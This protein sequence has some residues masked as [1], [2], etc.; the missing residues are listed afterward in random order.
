MKIFLLTGLLATIVAAEEPLLSCFYFN[1]GTGYLCQLT[2][3][4]PNGFDNFTEIDGIHLEGFTNENV[5][6]IHVA[7]GTST[8]IPRI[9]CD[10][11]PNIDQFD[12][13]GV[14]LTDID[15]NSFNGCSQIGWLYLSNNRISSISEMAFG[16]LRGLTLINLGDNLLTT[17][18]ENLFANQQNLTYL[19]LNNNLIGGFAAGT[20]RP[21]GNLQYLHIENLNITTFN[22]QFFTDN[23][24]LVYLYLGDN[25]ITLSANMFSGMTELR[26]ISLLNN[27]IS[28][29]PPGT[30]AGLPN[31]T[32]LDL[33]WNNF[34]NL[35]ADSFAGSGQLYHIDLSGNPLETIEE[36]AFRGLDAL[37]SLTLE[38]GRIRDLNSISLNNLPNLTYLALSI[39]SIEEIPAGFFE[40]MPRLDYIG[41][42]ANRIKTLRR[43]SFGNLTALRTLDLD[44]NIVNAID[45]AFIDDAVN[46]NTLNLDGNLCASNYFGNFMN[47]RDRYLPMLE[48]CFRNI[49]HIVDTTTENDGIYSFFEAPQPGIILRVRSDNEIQI[50]LTPFDFVW[51]PAIEIIIGSIN[52]T[53][54]AIRINDETNVVTVPTPNV[55][56]P[57]QWNDFRVTWAHQN[58]LVFNGNNTFPFMSYT[59]QQF[60]PVN[61]YGLRAVETRATWSVQPIFFDEI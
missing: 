57:D 6:A 58:V 8:I 3:N 18:P 37:L 24:N 42:W 50:S 40:S 17:L 28:E 46:L 23:S 7:W 10:T 43:S 13:F 12:F 60:F 22:S 45:K 29:I 44:R 48:R 36:D 25:R 56:R 59:M 21:L 26:F 31:L 38:R 15:D 5:T 9:I 51:T 33:N 14:G 53:R 49:R 11:F 55:I 32:A 34:T 41:L 47:S 61:F 30:F 39:N 27:G 54:S 1:I 35:R 16:N 20:F 4:N 2:I 52:N 19:T